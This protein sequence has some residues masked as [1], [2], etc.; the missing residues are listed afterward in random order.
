[1]ASIVTTQTDIAP[2]GTH[3]WTLY[4]DGS[5]VLQGPSGTINVAATPDTLTLAASI[6]A[7]NTAQTVEQSLQAKVDAGLAALAAFQTANATARSQLATAKATAT[8][9]STTATVTTVAQAQ[10]EVRNIYASVATALGQ[11]DAALAA[12]DTATRATATALRLTA[13][14][15]DSTSAT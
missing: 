4:D 3:I 8:T 7:A 1:M 11:L 12:L 5:V 2:D 9:K 6:A 14:R 13:G 15:L 10:T